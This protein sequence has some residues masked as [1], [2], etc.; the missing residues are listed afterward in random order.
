M[1][2]V[3]LVFFFFAF[4]NNLGFSKSFSGVFFGCEEV[5]FRF[6]W[7]VDQVL[8]IALGCSCSSWRSFRIVVKVFK[9]FS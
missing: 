7:W 4:L 9:L 5:L 2:S 6:F 8:E 3:A 1:F